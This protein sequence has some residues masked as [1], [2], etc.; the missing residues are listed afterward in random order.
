ME[1][2]RVW[3]AML[4]RLPAGKRITEH[5]DQNPNLNFPHRIHWV[6]KTNDKVVTRVE[7]KSGKLED[8]GA[9][10]EGEVFELNNVLR[11]D[12]HNGHTKKKRS[13]V[14]LILDIFPRRLHGVEDD[15]AGL[16]VQPPEPEEL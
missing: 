6:L 3:K 1:E 8:V 10:E 4:A 5:W 9:F 14:H 11:H 13:R 2:P 15:N 12:V 16:E 7:G